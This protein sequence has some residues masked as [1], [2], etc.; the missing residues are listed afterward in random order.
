MRFA[1][2]RRSGPEPAQA[3]PA[4]GSSTYQAWL[5]SR[6]EPGEALVDTGLSSAADC[7]KLRWSLGA[8]Q[9]AQFSRLLAR[10][11]ARD[12]ELF[13]NGDLEAE[14]S[15]INDLV[16]PVLKSVGLDPIAFGVMMPE[17]LPGEGPTTPPASGQ[18]P[19]GK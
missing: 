8:E 6:P 5:E 7:A 17:K 13:A 12:R 15:R 19:V 2:G 14:A 4:T 10:S 11:V 18:S 1:E 3:V 16:A 9:Q